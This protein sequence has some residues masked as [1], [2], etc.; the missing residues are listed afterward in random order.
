MLSIP[1]DVLVSDVMHKGVVTVP[2]YATVKD[3][4]IKMLSNNISSLVVTRKNS[5]IGII[6]D[7]D[8]VLRIIA[9]GKDPGMVLVREVMSSPIITVSHNSKIDEVAMLMLNKK[10]KKLPVIDDKNNLIGMLTYT[11][12]VTAYPGYVDVLKEL[13]K[14]HALASTGV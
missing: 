1:R 2:D 13:L 8:I 9:Q 3:A 14:V 7:R 5:A 4:A 10:I 11:D 6:T 12:L